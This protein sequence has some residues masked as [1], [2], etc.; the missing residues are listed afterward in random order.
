M[1]DTPKPCTGAE[2]LDAL[3][4]CL[5]RQDEAVSDLRVGGHLVYVRGSRTGLASRISGHGG[6]VERPSLPLGMEN[7][8]LALAGQLAAHDPEIEYARSLGMAA[9]NALIPPP[10]DPLRFKGQDL[11]LNRAAGKRL[12][13]VGHFPFVERLAGE[14]ASLDVLELRPGPGDLPA[15][16]AEKVLPEADA[17]LITGTTLLNG[18]LAGL[19]RHLRASAYVVL[20]GPSTPFAPSL[21]DFGIDALAGS[22]VR[23][24]DTAVADVLSGKPFR[25]VRGVESCVVFAGRGS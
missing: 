19:L 20:L 4:A 17:A 8:M 13:V 1:R 5:P 23:D 25:K 3:F 2:I 15:D 12:A 9:V 14:F 6:T 24:P 11:I 7:S 10:V 22:V 18:T 16:M 21:F